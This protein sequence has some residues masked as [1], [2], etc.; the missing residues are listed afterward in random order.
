MRFDWL[1]GRKAWQAQSLT[2]VD[3]MILD[4]ALGCAQSRMMANCRKVALNLEPARDL[5]KVM[6]MPVLAIYGVA[7]PAVATSHGLGFAPCSSPKHA[8]SSHLQ[9][10]RAGS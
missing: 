9:R 7:K 2:R 5:C 3:Q 4:W 8:F 6:K 10:S 1:D